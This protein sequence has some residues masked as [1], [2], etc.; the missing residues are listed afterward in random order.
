MNLQGQ[1]LVIRTPNLILCTVLPAEY[2]ILAR[3]PSDPKLWRDR[4]ITNPYGHFI[5]ESGPL[6]W[7]ISKV[8]RNPELAKYLLRLAVLSSTYEIIGS[9]GFHNGPDENGMIEIGLGVEPEFKGRGFAQEMLRGMW[10][11]ISADPLV[12]T[13]RYTV[14]PNNAPSQK[15][16]NNFGFTYIGQQIDEENAPEDIYE[17]SS[18]QY[19]V[20][21]GN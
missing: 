12:K 11:W 19:K 15:I 18:T 21:F 9:T 13:L 5:R 2:E 17:M 20:K 16:I 10:G 8:R 14:S 1:D 3:D 7:K 6:P 4:D